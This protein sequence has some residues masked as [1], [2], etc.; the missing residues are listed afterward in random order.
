MDQNTESDL[1]RAFSRLSGAVGSYLHKGAVGASREQLQ[2][3]R[4]VTRFFKD[5]AEVAGKSMSKIK[6]TAA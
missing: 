2:A 1:N 5:L 6:R 4:Q 3:S